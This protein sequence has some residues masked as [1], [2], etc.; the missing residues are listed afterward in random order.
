MFR[1][2]Q[3]R[4]PK[5]A[6]AKSRTLS[7]DSNT[8]FSAKLKVLRML[9]VYRI[10]KTKYAETAFDGEGACRFG[11]RWNSRGT[12]VVC[13]A[14]SIALAAL[15]MLVHL[16]DNEIL[17]D[18]S[19]IAA[20]IP[21][22]LILPVQDFRDLP[23][24]WSA[25]PA[26]PSAQRVGDNW[27]RAKVSALETPSSIVLIEKNCLLNPAH[28]DWSKIKLSRKVEQFVFDER[29]RRKKEV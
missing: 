15:E 7:A 25:S 22:E 21:T 29:I 11:G 6:H 19:F 16:N 24:D 18:Y 26:P 13:V 14:E 27:V 1:R 3:W 17:L 12:R 20:E 5:R 10:C 9:K 8:Q 2:S 4:R 23:L 28:R